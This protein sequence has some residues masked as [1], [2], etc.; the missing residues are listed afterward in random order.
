MFCFLP[1]FII[2]AFAFNNEKKAKHPYY[3]SVTEINYSNNEKQLQIDCKIFTDDFENT[4]KLIH[5]RQVDLYHP[6][7]TALIKKQ[8]ETYII[9]HL[10]ISVDKTNIPLHFEGYEI[11]GEAAWCYFSAACSK[12]PK[13]IDVFNDL[14]YQYKKEQVNITHVKINSDRKS[15]RLSYPDTQASFNF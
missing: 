13:N 3:I 5:N 4:L 7:D 8:I 15:E 1:L 11:E 14:L 12:Q 2:T 10:K 9:N 6:K